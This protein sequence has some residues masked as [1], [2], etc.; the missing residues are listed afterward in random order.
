MT[1]HRVSAESVDY[2]E[3]DGAQKSADCIHVR[4]KGGVSSKLGCCNDFNPKKG[5]KLFS[6]GTCT[7]VRPPQYGMYR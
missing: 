2:M 6:C 3:L 1:D 4:V 7:M 5:V